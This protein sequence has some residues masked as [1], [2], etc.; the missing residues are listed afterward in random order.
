V[1]LEKS[2]QRIAY[3]NIDKGLIG[4]TSLGRD[5]RHHLEQRKD[6]MGQRTGKGGVEEQIIRRSGGI[7]RG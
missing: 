4:M 3:G 7:G 6:N 1:R 2:I 5:R